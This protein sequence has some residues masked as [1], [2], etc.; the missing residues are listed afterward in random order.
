MYNKSNYN[1]GFQVEY[2]D[3]QHNL[4]ITEENGSVKN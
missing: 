1:G 3:D 4:D 2:N